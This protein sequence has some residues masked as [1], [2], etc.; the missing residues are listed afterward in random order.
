MKLFLE[1]EVAHSNDEVERFLRDGQGSRDSVC[2]GS[3]IETAAEESL[4][5]ATSAPLVIDC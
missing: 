2:S 5:R 3:S 1:H 4:A